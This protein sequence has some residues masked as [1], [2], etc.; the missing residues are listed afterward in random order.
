VTAAEQV[1]ATQADLVAKLR[2]VLAAMLQW[3]GYQEVVSM[4]R[5]I[6]RLQEELNAESQGEAV[7]GL[8]DIFDE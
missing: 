1:D 2:A 3:E 5:D 4:L 6:L 7:G 8:D